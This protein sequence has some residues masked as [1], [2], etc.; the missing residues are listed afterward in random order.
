MFLIYI[1][2]EWSGKRGSNPRPW[3]WE[4]HALP[5]ELLPQK[6]HEQQKLCAA[7]CDTM[8]SQFDG[9]STIFWGSCKLISKKITLF[10]LKFNV[11]S[12]VGTI[13]IR[14]GLLKRVVVCIP[15][16]CLQLFRLA[17]ISA[18][19]CAGIRGGER[20][21]CNFLQARAETLIRRAAGGG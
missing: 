15:E 9:K 7:V 1:I 12:F 13:I 16:P 20:R 4:A 3:A 17:W 6:K 2:N 19:I 14:I 5:T 18:F 21:V 11:F 10:Y 8:N